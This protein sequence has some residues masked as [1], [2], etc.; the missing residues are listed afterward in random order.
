MRK[1]SVTSERGNGFSGYV[2]VM[3]LRME[4]KY[5]WLEVAVVC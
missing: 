5:V 4:V 1:V 3:R 2:H